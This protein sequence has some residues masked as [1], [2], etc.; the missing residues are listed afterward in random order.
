MLISLNRSLAKSRGIK[1]WLI[2]ALFSLVVAVVVTV[3]I[4]WVGLLVINSMLILPAAAA[5]NI[6]GNTRQYVWWSIA[7]SLA[8]GIAGLI[9]SYYLSTATGAT[10]VLVSMGAFL[11][12]LVAKKIVP[13]N[14]IR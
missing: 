13:T 4:R 12:T 2:E 10:I 8:S 6:S 9:A 3:S 5:R 1:V 7:I 11:I 14:S